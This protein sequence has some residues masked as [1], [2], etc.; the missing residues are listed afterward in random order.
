V[1][2]KSNGSNVLTNI[3]VSSN[4]VRFLDEGINTHELTRE[5]SLTKNSEELEVIEF[6]IRD[7]SGGEA[8]ISVNIELDENGGNLEPTWYQ[9]ITLKAQSTEGVNS[10]FS[11]ADGTIFSLQDAF[12]NQSNVH[13]LYYYDTVDSDENTVSS[14]GANIDASIF[15]GDFGLENWTTRNTLRFLPVSIT[16]TE[17]ESI[18]SVLYLVEAYTTSGTRKAKNLVPGNVFSFKDESRNK[19]GMFRVNSITGESTGEINITIVVQP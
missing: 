11:L 17:F 15:S 1:E 10:F 16:Q 19:Y 2:C 18:N 12:N 7:I 14:P 9:N 5:V 3:I 13:L 8:S 4:G 6:T